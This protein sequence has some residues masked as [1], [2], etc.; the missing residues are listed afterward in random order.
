[1]HEADLA[2]RLVEQFGFSHRSALNIIME[3]DTDEDDD[4]AKAMAKEA[5]PDDP[6]KQEDLEKKFK[7]M[8]AKQEAKKRK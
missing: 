2:V 3:A 5:A 8:L 7:E 4:V 1:M 6:K